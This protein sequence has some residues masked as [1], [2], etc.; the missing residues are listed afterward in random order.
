MLIFT[1]MVINSTKIA[2]FICY[3]ALSY[4]SIKTF[5]LFFEYYNRISILP[6][7][8]LTILPIIDNILLG[9]IYVC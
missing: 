1:K 9:D 3:N 6:F 2:L 7:N 4:N 8:L 5:K